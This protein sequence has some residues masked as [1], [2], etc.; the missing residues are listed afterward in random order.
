ME[1]KIQA[2][3]LSEPGQITVVM[4]KKKPTEKVNHPD[5]YQQCSIE[6]ID[7]MVM[8]FGVIDTMNACLWNAYK[9]LWRYKYKN[10]YEDV[11]KAK[12][13]LNEYDMLNGLYKPFI[14][15]S[16]SADLRDILGHLSIKAEQEY[17]KDKIYHGE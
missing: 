13:Y 12:W 6:C 2:A 15:T 1:E 8:T 11:K 14:S 17:M 3:P 9:Y 16:R 10:G 7:A 4:E 5:H